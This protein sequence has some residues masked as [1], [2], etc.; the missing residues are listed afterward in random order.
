MKAPNIKFQLPENFQIPTPNEIA[1]KCC[2]HLELGLW[3]LF[4]AWSLEFGAF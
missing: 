1:A 3:D 4:A 2:T